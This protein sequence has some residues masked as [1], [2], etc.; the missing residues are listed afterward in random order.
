MILEL[1]CQVYCQVVPPTK[2]N[3]LENLKKNSGELIDFRVWM[4]AACLACFYLASKNN[5][6]SALEDY[7]DF[8][9]ATIQY[10]AIIV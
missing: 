4:A 9:H 5:Q 3:S 1:Y 2:I 7:K 8:C 6:A 10:Q